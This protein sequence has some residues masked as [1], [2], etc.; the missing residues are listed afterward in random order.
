MK[1][2]DVRVEEG[3]KNKVFLLKHNENGRWNKV[4][5]KATLKKL[6]EC[7]KTEKYRVVEWSIEAREMYWKYC[8]KRSRRNF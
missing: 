1:T 8:K 7:L 5:T 2:I 6:Y 3:P 4:G